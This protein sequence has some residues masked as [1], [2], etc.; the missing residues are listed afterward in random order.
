VKETS[1]WTSEYKLLM[2]WRVKVRNTSRTAA[3]KDIHFK[4]RYY[5]DRVVS[6]NW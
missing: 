1:R 5:G 3:Y 6:V 2:E 4:T